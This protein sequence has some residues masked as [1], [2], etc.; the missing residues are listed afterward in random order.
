MRKRLK[1]IKKKKK[2]LK[3]C[4]NKSLGEN[5]KK[6]LPLFHFLKCVT[7]DK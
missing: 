7:Y 5:R 6:N 4:E 2:E 3:P 1:T